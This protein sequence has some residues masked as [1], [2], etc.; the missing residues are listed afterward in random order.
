MEKVEI[1]KQ[2]VIGWVVV[3]R[4]DGDDSWKVVEPIVSVIGRDRD[5]CFQEK[6]FDFDDNVLGILQAAPGTH[7]IT[8]T[9]SDELVVLGISH[10]GDGLSDD[11]WLE[12]AE[13][14]LRFRAILAERAK[15]L[16]LEVH[17]A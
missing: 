1:N 10:P 16:E 15:L 7:R 11:Y 6:Q 3:T 5:G 13:D 17:H 12:E 4:E 9:H 2:Q 14:E 8:T